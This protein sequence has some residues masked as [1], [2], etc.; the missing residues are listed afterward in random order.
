LHKSKEDA[1]R[2]EMG[3]ESDSDDERNGRHLQDDFDDEPQARTPVKK[4]GRLDVEETRQD[5]GGAARLRFVVGTEQQRC[6]QCHTRSLTALL[7]VCVLPMKPSRCVPA[8][9]SGSAE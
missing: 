5:P 1:L 8:L 6:L 7:Q 2:S 9:L 3:I 4:P